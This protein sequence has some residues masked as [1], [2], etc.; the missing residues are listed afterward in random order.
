MIDGSP[1]TYLHVFTYSPRPG[2]PA[3]AMPDQVPVNVARE[4]N[5]I[6]RELA[7]EKKS[8]FMG[9]FIGKPIEAITLN[10]ESQGT[11]EAFTG[12][13][14]HNYLK[15]RLAGRHPANRWVQAQVSGVE[16]GSLIGGVA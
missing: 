6:L 7:E 15:L 11:G 13:L 2:T 12:A 8:A 10:E 9:L 16:T 14:T 3:A 1:L 4:R 5:R